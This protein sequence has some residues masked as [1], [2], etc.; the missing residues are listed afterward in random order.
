MGNFGRR[1]KAAFVLLE[2][3][4]RGGIRRYYLILFSASEFDQIG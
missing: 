3:F 1:L 2:I 4:L